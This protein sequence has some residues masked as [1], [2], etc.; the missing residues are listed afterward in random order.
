LVILILILCSLT[1]GPTQTLFRTVRIQSP[2]TAGTRAADVTDPADA[3]SSESEMRAQIERYTVDRGS[4]T[5]SYPVAISSARATRF[6][7]FYSDW[8][9]QLQKLNFDSLS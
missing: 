4:L 2:S 9:A 1:A 8:L 5:R 6:R 3:N 7:Q